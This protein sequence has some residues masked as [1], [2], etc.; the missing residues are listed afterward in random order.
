MATV[1]PTQ[2]DPNALAS[3]LIQQQ[4]NEWEATFQPIELQ[5]MQQISWNNPDV[6]PNDL[7]TAD[8]QA[9]G[10]SQQMGGILSRQNAAMGV[11]PTAAQTTTTNRMLNIDQ[12]L[13]VA[14]AENTAR[15]NQRALDESIL[16]GTSPNPNIVNSQT[17][18]LPIS[19]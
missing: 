2:T 8:A 6:L 10:A 17:A 11:T 16:M 18:N 14:G 9:T 15:I 13:N 4:Y 1:D 12:S 3:Q 5:A 19:V 7:A